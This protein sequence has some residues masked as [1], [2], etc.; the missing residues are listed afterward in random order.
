MD[1]TIGAGS[2]VLGGRDGRSRGMGGRLGVKVGDEQR[3]Q[4]ID[5]GQQPQTQ[6]IH[7][8]PCVSPCEADLYHSI[9][10]NSESLSNVQTLQFGSSGYL[11]LIRS[12]D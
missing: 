3:V 9:L 7:I 10:I 4:E 1:L 5:R 8:P 12:C 6:R 2:D 11:I